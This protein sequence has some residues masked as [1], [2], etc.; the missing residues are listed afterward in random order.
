MRELE[1]LLLDWLERHYERADEER[2]AQFAALLEL[3]DP[4]LQA[5]LL[6]AES[7]PASA[8]TIIEA[9]RASR[10]AGPAERAPEAEGAS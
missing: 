2:R 9:I 1:L 3:P 6:G 10:G 8:R 4:L 5:Y 7:P